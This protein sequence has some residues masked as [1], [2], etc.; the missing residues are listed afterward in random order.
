MSKL[1]VT[2]KLS[3]DDLRHLRALL[4][5]TG[6]RMESRGEARIVRDVEEMLSRVRTA[7]PPDYIRARLEKLEGLIGMLKDVGW[8]MPAATRRSAIRALA[9]FAEPDDLIPDSTP[10]LGFLDDA[11]MTELI[12]RQLRHE[13]EGYERF[14]RFRHAQWERPWYSQGSVTREARLV[15]RRREIRAKIRQREDR[16]AARSSIERRPSRWP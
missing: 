5:D 2:F 4:R 11:I 15:A 7:S 10:G 1:K 13:I 16:E 9:Y 3:E 14:R 8:P 12:V 6:A